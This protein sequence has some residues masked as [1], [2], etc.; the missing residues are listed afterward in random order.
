MALEL[1]RLLGEARG[2][3]VSRIDGIDIRLHPHRANSETGLK[4][5]IPVRGSWAE[6]WCPETS[7]VLQYEAL[8]ASQGQA[9][10]IFGQ[11]STYHGISPADAVESQEAISFLNHKEKTWYARPHPRGPF[12]VDITGGRS[13]SSQRQFQ[14]GYFVQRRLWFAQF[15]EGVGF[16]ITAFEV[17]WSNRGHRAVFLGQRNDGRMFTVNPRAHHQAAELSWDTDDIA[18]I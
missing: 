14:W 4:E 12:R 6:E 11:A 7:P 16:F 15:F 9:S 10:S 5:A 2:V 1:F 8:A 17:A 18:E 13:A 3:L